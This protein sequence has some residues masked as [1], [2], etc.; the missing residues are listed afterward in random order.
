MVLGDEYAVRIEWAHPWDTGAPMPRVV[1]SGP[2]VL[3]LY[4]TADTNADWDGTHVTVVDPAG[5]AAQELAVVRFERCE[6]YKLAPP[7]EGVL[8]RHPLHN[9]GLEPYAAHVVENSSWIVEYETIN[10]TRLPS[11][12][13][14]SPDY[15]HYLLVFHDEIFECIATR[16]AI[17]R[18]RGTFAEALSHCEKHVL[19]SDG[20]SEIL[21]QR[22]STATQYI[23]PK[24]IVHPHGPVEPAKRSEYPVPSSEEYEP[25]SGSSLPLSWFIVL[26]LLA[27]VIFAVRSCA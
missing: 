10:G 18:F 8:A 6:A 13:G 4:L 16:Y 15:A 1:S 12:S 11:T 2:V 24:P 9:K 3:L 25:P 17:D 27:A 26:G 19:E 14:E 5:S 21:A 20:G 7:D 22:G 23:V